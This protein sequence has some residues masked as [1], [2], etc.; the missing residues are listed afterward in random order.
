VTISIPSYL[1]DILRPGAS[2]VGPVQQAFDKL[3]RRRS[4]ADS[5]AAGCATTS[6]VS[7]PSSTTT[8]SNKTIN[9][10]ATQ[11]TPNL[12]L[13]SR[14]N[15]FRKN[16]SETSDNFEENIERNQ[17][18]HDKDKEFGLDLE[19]SANLMDMGM[20]VSLR[21]GGHQTSTNVN[22]GQALPQDAVA[23]VCLCV[24]HVGL[25]FCHHLTM[26]AL[27]VNQADFKVYM[28][29]VC[30][31]VSVCVYECAYACVCASVPV[32]ACVCA[33]ARACACACA[34]VCACI[35]A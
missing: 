23:K 13:P 15:L 12:N 6:S 10:A 7:P 29:V 3:A 20:G 33:C 24:C 22:L 35:Y 4:T 32:C 5:E 26:V 16:S 28:Y 30:V 9:T 14:D 11:S 18:H 27:A 34:C 1:L 2:N 31:C 21:F 19:E 17:P 25:R 8:N